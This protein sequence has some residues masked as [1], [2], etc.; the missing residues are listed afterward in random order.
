MSR[1]QII[2]GVAY[3]RADKVLPDDALDFEGDS[4]VDPEGKGELYDPEPPESVT[5]FWAEYARVEVAHH[6]PP[7]P[8]APRS[9]RIYTDQGT[10]NFPPDHLIKVKEPEGPT[11]LYQ[12]GI[13]DHW[14]RAAWDGDCREDAERFDNDQVNDFFGNEGSGWVE[15]P[16]PGTES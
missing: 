8:Q 11:E 6:F 15:V 3:V 7:A 4:I 5:I 14:H 16:M 10:F 1:I 12:C 2:E 13:C 9:I